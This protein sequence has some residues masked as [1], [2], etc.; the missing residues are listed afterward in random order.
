M[1][2]GNIPRP[3]GARFDDLYD[4]LSAAIGSNEPAK[5]LLG[6]LVDLVTGPAQSRPDIP[7]LLEDL[8]SAI[9]ESNLEAQTV[10]GNVM[11]AFERRPEPV[12]DL[13]NIQDRLL[14]L[15]STFRLVDQRLYD[16]QDV[17][18][19][20]QPAA[21]VLH[22]AVEELDQLHNA[23]DGWNS[24]HVYRPK[25]DADREVPAESSDDPGARVSV[26][27]HRQKLLGVL[28]NLQAMKAAVRY[29]QPPDELEATVELLED[30]VQR[31]YTALEETNLRRAEEAAS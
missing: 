7:K 20:F 25:T 3:G 4:S 1:A 28:G 5:R 21:V 8:A 19:E 24:S 22:R 31:V 27:T 17:P 15:V 18:E 10:L 2:S 16:L 26:E 29:G 12:P 23:L 9:G 11:E 13:D 30:E 14:D 6:E